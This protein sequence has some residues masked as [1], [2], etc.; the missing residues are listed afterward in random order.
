MCFERQRHIFSIFIPTTFLL[1]LFYHTRI[2]FVAIFIIISYFF[3]Y[4]FQINKN[5]PMFYSE[6]S[7]ESNDLL[8]GTLCYVL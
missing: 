8:S 1:I 7:Y 2:S 5:K 4:N 6:S 3:A